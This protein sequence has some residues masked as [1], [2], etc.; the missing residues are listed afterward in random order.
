MYSN[1][2]LNLQLLDDSASNMSAASHH[3]LFFFYL[4]CSLLPVHYTLFTLLLFLVFVLFVLVVRI[5]YSSVF[6]LSLSYYGFYTVSGR[7]FI[8]MFMQFKVT[9]TWIEFT[10]FL[11]SYFCLHLVV[12]F[13]L[14]FM[15]PS[16]HSTPLTCHL[17]CRGVDW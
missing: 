1:K 5:T 14:Y 16:S 17:F 7:V 3:V 12:F 2:S 8:L 10:S 4:S 6:C 9:L 13:N 15:F 11:S